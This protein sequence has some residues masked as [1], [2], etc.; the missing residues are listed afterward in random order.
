MNPIEIHID[1]LVLEG[2]SPRDRQTVAEAAAYELARLTAE[3]GL[4]SADTSRRAVGRID[5]GTLQ[6]GLSAHPRALGA[7]I[8]RAIHENLG[9][10]HE[11]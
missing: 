5:A 1:E 7:E 9:T 6:L 2:V 11:R 10:P 4:P 3:W 8:A